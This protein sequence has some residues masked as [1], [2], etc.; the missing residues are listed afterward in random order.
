LRDDAEAMLRF[1]SG[2][3]RIVYRFGRFPHRNTILGRGSSLEEEAF[4][5]AG[6]GTNGCRV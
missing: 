5:A 4:L 6:D 3:R 2:H 1:A